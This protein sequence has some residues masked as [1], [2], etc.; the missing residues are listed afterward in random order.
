MF[1]KSWRFI[2]PLLFIAGCGDKTEVKVA[3]V[4]PVLSKEEAGKPVTGDWLIIH[5]LSDPEQLNPL[6]SSDAVSSEISG[7]IFEALLTRDPR[8]L[9][10][11]TAISP[12]RG[13]KFQKINL[14]YTFKI[15]K[16]ARFQDGRPLTGEDV[17]FSVKAIKCPFVNAPFLRVYFNSLIDAELLDP[18]TIRFITKEPYFKNESVLGGSISPVAPPSLRSG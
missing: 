4:K 9:E 2:I 12:R 13:R 17:L 8:T 15:R 16:D 5:S 7:Y 11:Q 1:A 6:T 3:D 10:I 18:Y 14:T